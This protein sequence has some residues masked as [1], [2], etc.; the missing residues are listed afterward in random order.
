[1]EARQQLLEQRQAEREWRIAEKDGDRR[2]L[3]ATLNTVTDVVLSVGATAA[4]IGIV[5]TSTDEAKVAFA[6]FLAGA[7]MFRVAREFVLG[8][9]RIGNP[10]ANQDNKS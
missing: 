10:G 5:V 6:A 4:G 2:R 8:Y 7:G 1:M 3:L 9:F